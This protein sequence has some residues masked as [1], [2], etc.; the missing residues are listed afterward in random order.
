[1]KVS[2]EFC[3]VLRQL[4][5]MTRTDVETPTESPTAADVLGLLAQGIPALE[6]R[7]ANTACAIGTEVVPR[8]TI[9]RSGESLVLIPPVS[10]G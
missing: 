2:V 9:I 3:G 1:M 8:S 6:I 5:G 10:G 4:A 7:L